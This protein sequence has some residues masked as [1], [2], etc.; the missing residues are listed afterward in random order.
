M[1]ASDLGRASNP[2]LWVPSGYSAAIVPPPGYSQERTIYKKKRFLLYPAY[3]S[4]C[5]LNISKQEADSKQDYFGRLDS[6]LSFICQVQK[7]K[8]DCDIN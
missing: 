1:A 4:R 2:N 8:V 7:L 6:G 3:L 5:S